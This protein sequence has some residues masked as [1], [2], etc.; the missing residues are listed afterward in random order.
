MAVPRKCPHCKTQIPL[1]GGFH[2]DESMNLICDK[3]EKVAFPAT[4]LVQPV[5]IKPELR[6]S[7]T[8]DLSKQGWSSPAQWGQQDQALCDY[9]VDSQD[10]T[11]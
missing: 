9:P 6:P 5:L 1:D 7:P 8:Q 10:D 3:C 4:P 2:F 11:E